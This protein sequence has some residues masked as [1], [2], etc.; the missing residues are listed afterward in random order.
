MFVCTCSLNIWR[1]EA[2]GSS[3]QG[4][5]QASLDNMR[6]CLQ[7]KSQK[8]KKES[9]NSYTQEAVVG[10]SQASLSFGNNSLSQN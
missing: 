10:E 4:E 5:F 2:G 8:P 6:L 9:C 7:K 3:I 1:V